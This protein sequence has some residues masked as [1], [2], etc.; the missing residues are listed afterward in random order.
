M[1][2]R[3]I[4]ASTETIDRAVDAHWLLADDIPAD[5]VAVDLAFLLLGES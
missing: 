4:K 5:D 3:L 1:T 2:F